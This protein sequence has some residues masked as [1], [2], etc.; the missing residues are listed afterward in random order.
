MRFLRLSTRW[1]SVLLL[2]VGAFC[3][4]VPRGEAA[5]I[6]DEL[7][8][9]YTYLDLA[10]CLDGFNERQFFEFMYKYAHIERTP[11][12]KFILGVMY[13]HGLGVPRD[14]GKAARWYREAAEAG[15]RF[16]MLGAEAEIGLQRLVDEGL[17][18]PDAE[19]ETR[20]TEQEEAIAVASAK[21][22]LRLGIKYHY[23][24]C[25]EL[26]YDKARAWQIWAAENGD[27]N[28]RNMVA[29]NYTYGEYGY[30]KDEERGRGWL[31]GKLKKDPGFVPPVRLPD[32]AGA[33][34]P[35]AA[36]NDGAS[37]VKG[38]LARKPAT[39]DAAPGEDRPPQAKP[40]SL[41]DYAQEI[42]ETGLG[43]F[44]GGEDAPPDYFLAGLNFTEAAAFG[45]AEPECHFLLGEIQERGMCGE[46]NYYGAGK[47]YRIA[48]E[49]GQV[50]AM[51]RLAR[52]HEEGLGVR[53]SLAEA[54]KWYRAA[55]E[56]GMPG[57]AE[58]A[59]RVA[60]QAAEQAE[61][62]WEVSPEMRKV[63][64]DAQLRAYFNRSAFNL[65]DEM[66][67]AGRY[68]VKAAENGQ[69][70]AQFLAHRFF[71]EGDAKLGIPKDPVRAKEFLD[72]A[73]RAGV[74]EKDF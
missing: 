37:E 60:E 46:V 29:D 40:Q 71:L 1:R 58:A 30:P 69:P 12:H 19:P 62:E 68:L 22:M 39:G 13:H 14:Y 10:E 26:D 63:F 28:A 9:T 50:A 52:L 42:F 18:A 35:P 74:T 36:D 57:A 61:E 27:G 45:L 34:N 41:A 47:S 32:G 56:A 44:R 73:A 64:A 25:A 8:R 66:L 53:R 70:Y 38:A 15:Y 5:A 21:E 11:E 2:A 7:L 43:Y 3:L 67:S 16:R 51:F 49:M 54:G 72:K 23:G 6:K 20:P 65:P 31:H 59:A 4:C 33:A 55:A 24:L 48:A 17:F